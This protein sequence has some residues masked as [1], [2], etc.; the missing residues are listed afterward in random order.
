MALGTTE[1]KTAPTLTPNAGTLI[2]YP[3]FGC[4]R[5]EVGT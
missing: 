2:A 4:V 5:T 3:P 1:A